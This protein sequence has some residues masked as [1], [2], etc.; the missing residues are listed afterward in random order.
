MAGPE[1]PSEVEALENIAQA[2]HSLQATVAIHEGVGI[3]Q[4]PFDVMAILTD[5]SARD[6]TRTALWTGFLPRLEEHLYV[7]RGATESWDREALQVLKD[8]GMEGWPAV[9]GQMAKDMAAGAE[10]TNYNLK[11]ICDAFKKLDPRMQAVAVSLRAG[12]DGVGTTV[13]SLESALVAALAGMELKTELDLEEPIKDLVA[14]LK[15]VLA[16]QTKSTP[17]AGALFNKTLGGTQVEATIAAVDKML[18]PGAG[19]NPD[20]L[21]W[22]KDGINVA[23]R[24][25]ADLIETVVNALERLLSPNPGELLPPARPGASGLTRCFTSMYNYL[26]RGGLATPESVYS[27]V[28]QAYI[29]A[30]GLGVVAH[31]I[32]ALASVDVLGCVDVNLR[33]LA[34]FVGTLAGFQPLADAVHGT[35]YKNYIRVPLNYEA[36]RWSRPYLPGIGDLMRF[37]FKRIFE[38]GRGAQGKPE[39]PYTFEECMAFYGFSDPWIKI[40][41]DDVYREPMARDLLMMAEVKDFGEEWWSYKIKR[42]GYDD[43][44]AELMVD[45]FKRRSART[46]IVGL[47][48]AWQMLYRKGYCTLDE[49]KEGA[50]ETKLTEI[51]IEYGVAQAEAQR[52]LDI[53]TELLTFAKTRYTRGDLT[54]DEFRDLLDKV[55]DD[56]ARARRVFQIE[57]LKRFRAVYYSRPDELARKALPVYKRSFVAG[58]STASEYKASLIAAGMEPDMATLT[59][60]LDSEARDRGVFA[61][62]R[63]FGL[64]ALRDAYLHGFVS[65]ADYRRELRE[66]GFPEEY[67]EAELRLIAAL[68]RRRLEA[69][70]RSYE[71]PHFRRGYIVGLVTRTAL[72]SVFTEAGVSRA[73]ADTELMTLDWQRDEHERRATEKAAADRARAEA[74][75]KREADMARKLAERQAEE[76]RRAAERR[77]REAERLAAEAER[78]IAENL[79]AAALARRLGWPADVDRIRRT[80]G[81]YYKAHNMILPDDVWRLSLTLE[82]ELLAAAGPDPIRVDSLIGRIEQALAIHA[83]VMPTPPAEPVAA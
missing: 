77:E 8:I 51:C 63:A 40:Y 5:A 38:P 28:A 83:G 10:T 80:L 81:T 7:I 71:L 72:R 61:R 18:K 27:R 43:T 31:G 74:K 35:L 73:V 12:L 46:Y 47:F 32:S 29:M 49:F 11:C 70:V 21:G 58:L 20:I 19:G 52:Q 69:Q 6:E 68:L 56:P 17:H 67:L 1:L 16:D 78:K 2:V 62:F 39:A 24:Y 42:L 50:R 23:V 48:A 9:W 13:T 41:K 14:G 76:R 53:K 33:G 44:D 36:N 22:A 55:F 3:A 64:P 26:T 15:D 45:A 37:K 60:D 54:D 82:D 25:G 4:L 30:S 75:V 79:K 34:G 59:L 66:K 65:D 57:R